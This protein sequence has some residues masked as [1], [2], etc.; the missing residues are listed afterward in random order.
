M[1]DEVMKKYGKLIYILV[2]IAALVISYVFGFN[3]LLASNDDIN[4]EI[5]D[6]Q[7][8]YN[9]LNA[10]YSNK[11]KYI[12]DTKSIKKDY[13]TMLKKFDAGITDE[14]ILV[15]SEDFET[16]LGVSVTSMTLQDIVEGYQFGQVQSHNPADAGALSGMD[17]G[18]KG[19]SSTYTMT[20][21]GTY[22]QIFDLLETFKNG[23]KR[24]V[25]TG[26]T[27]TYDAT[28]EKVTCALDMAEYAIKGG[29]R[30]MS[31]IQIKQSN[32]GQGNIFFSQLYQVNQQ[33]EGSA[34]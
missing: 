16:K 34:Q 19:I 29:D 8:K 17:S 5:S 1:N 23:N 4:S 6:L 22:K 26:L 2:G 7:T 12:K 27:F 32:E 31:D 24:K 21:A 25:P 9:N 30:K 33:D 14:S 20:A 3:K 28:N 11:A 13:E 10:D 15:D 18:Y